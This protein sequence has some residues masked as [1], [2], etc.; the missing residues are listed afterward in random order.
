MNIPVLQG[1]T[2]DGAY[3]RDYYLLRPTRVP[4]RLATLSIAA[5]LVAAV[6]CGWGDHS[7]PDF[8]A[9]SSTLWLV[10]ALVSALLITP[11]VFTVGYLLSLLPFLIAW[12]VAAM[13]GALVLQWVASI[14]AVVLLL[15]FIDCVASD[16]PRNRGRP[17]AWLGTL[18]WQATLVRLCFGLN[19][20]C[21]STEKIFAGLGS[22]HHLEQGF[23]GL[24]ITHGAGLF[25]VLGGLIELA[26][27]ISVGLG[28]FARLGALVSLVYFLVATVGFG[29]E[30]SRGYAWASPG[31]GGWEYVMM[32]LV[33][34]GGVMLTGAGKFSLDGWLLQRG[35]VPRPL[36][37][38][39]TNAEGARGE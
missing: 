23:Q 20:L 13:N 2:V 14:A 21:H 37:P 7:L 33:V 36:V 31:G 39:C 28:L 1:D 5:A 6:Y 15:Q 9:W 16:W 8:A 17:G 10:V 26:S 12:R 11:R 4:H 19:E 34:F 24:G 32:L 35:A 30:W 29:G 25:V 18:L 38:L 3:A 27:A 22:F